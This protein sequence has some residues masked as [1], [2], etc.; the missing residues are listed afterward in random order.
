MHRL[1]AERRPGG[2]NFLGDDVFPFTT[3]TGNVYDSGRYM[4]PLEVAAEAEYDSAYTFIYS[5]RPGTEAAELVDQYVDPAVIADRFDRL[6]IVLER[7]AL[8]AAVRSARV[9]APERP[10]RPARRR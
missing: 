3:L 8:D 5:P 7:S 6:K 10:D 4:F 1:R 9:R 2:S